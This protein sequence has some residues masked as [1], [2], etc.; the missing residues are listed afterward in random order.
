MDAHEQGSTAVPQVLVMQI[1]HD[2]FADLDRKRQPFGAAALAPHHY[3]PLAPV[4]VIEFER[5][6]LPRAQAEAGQ[7]R[8][9]REVT[10]SGRGSDPAPWAA[11]GTAPAS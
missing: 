1:A 6:D 4:N 8:Q 11:R 10:P 9:D 7:H 2:G 3:R 5:G